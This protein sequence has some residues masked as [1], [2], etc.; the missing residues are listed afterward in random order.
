[1]DKYLIAKLYLKKLKKNGLKEGKLYDAGESNILVVYHDEIFLNINGEIAS[2]YF[3][4]NYELS[5]EQ[6]KFLE[7]ESKKYVYDVNVKSYGKLTADCIK[8]KKIEIG[9][10]YMGIFDILGQPKSIN[11]TETTN[12]L[13]QQFIYPNMN[14]YTEGQFV[15]AIQTH[16]N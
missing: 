9:M 4:T 7:M 6:E 14:I 3:L 10:N 15:T 5:P 11:T 2:T 16:N 1:M 13:K 12:G 8:D